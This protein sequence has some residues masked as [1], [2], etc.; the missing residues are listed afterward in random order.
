MSLEQIDRNLTTLRHIDGSWNMPQMPE[1]VML[2]LAI[3][4]GMKSENL[5]SL[6]YGA[7]NEI[8]APPTPSPIRL[9]PSLDAQ[10][11]D[12]PQIDPAQPGGGESSARFLTRW[13]SA[14]QGGDRPLEVS[15]TNNQAVFDWKRR[16]VQDGYIEMDDAELT[17]PR[18]RPEYNSINYD[19]TRDRM[20]RDFMG[21]EEGALSIRE[22]GN[23]FD[24]WLSPSG[25]ARA[26]IE[27]DL[28]WDYG[29]IKDEFMDWPSKARKWWSDVSSV[30]SP[31]GAGPIDVAKSTM[32]MVTGPLDEALVPALNWFLILSGVGNTFLSVKGLSLGAASVTGTKLATGMEATRRAKGIGP[33]A[34]ALTPA[35]RF[36]TGFAG[37]AGAAGTRLTNFGRPSGLSNYLVGGIGGQYTGNVVGRGAAAVGQ[38]MPG[39]AV[40][41][42][43]SLAE[44]AVWMG[45]KMQQWRNLRA[46]QAGKVGFQNVWKTGLGLRSIE[47]VRPGDREDRGDGG[48]ALEDVGI[49]SELRD[50]YLYPTSMTNIAGDLVFDLMFTPYTLF[51]PGTIKSVMRGAGMIKNRS[52]HATARVLPSVRKHLA[53][54]GHL[55]SRAI[56][57]FHDASLDFLRRTDPDLAAEYDKMAQAEG[58]GAALSKVFFNG[59][60]DDFGGAYVHALYSIGIEHAARQTAN[61]L[62]GVKENYSRNPIYNTVKAF[63]EGQTRYLDPHDMYGNLAEIASQVEIG[64]AVGQAAK[65]L[66]DDTIIQN[67]LAKLVDQFLE[68]S[69][70]A[71][72]RGGNVVD[73]HVRLIRQSDPN[74]LDYHHWRPLRHGEVPDVDARITDLDLEEYA[75]FHGRPLDEVKDFFNNPEPGIPGGLRVDLSPSFEGRHRVHSWGEVQA[76]TARR[77]DSAKSRWMWDTEIIAPGDELIP[78]DR[79]G[80]LKGVVHNHNAKRD[81]TIADLINNLESGNPN[82]A[83]GLHDMIPHTGN[84]PA[85]TGGAKG[86][87][88]TVPALHNALTDDFLERFSHWN[89]YVAA[90]DQLGEE[91]SRM[92]MDKAQYL[93][94]L[95]HGNR[96]LGLFPFAKDDP[97]RPRPYAGHLF[98]ESAGDYSYIEWINQGMYSPLVRALDQSKGRY[99]LARMGTVTKQ[100]AIEF[101]AQIKYRYDMLRTIRRFKT[102]GLIGAVD[103]AV[104]EVVQNAGGKLGQRA[105]ANFIKQ[106]MADEAAAGERVLSR[107]FGGKTQGKFSQLAEAVMSLGDDSPLNMQGL[108]DLLVEELTSFANSPEWVARFGLKELADAGHDAVE[109]ARKRSKQLTKES[110]WMAAE[111]DPRTLDAP[112]VQSMADK[113][114]KVVHGVSFTDPRK[115]GNLMPELGLHQSHLTS[116]L[117]LGLSRQNPYWLSN[118]RMRTTKSTLAGALASHASMV[119][120]PTLPVYKGQQRV[121]TAA[122]IRDEFASGDPNS[123]GVRQ[124]ID[125][126]QRMVDEINQQNQ[127]ALDAV[128]LGF[129]TGPSKIGTRLKASRTPYSVPDLGARR[130]SEM[131]KRIMALDYSEE[132]FHAIWEGLKKAR[133]LQDGL[134]VRGLA[135]LEDH[136]RSRPNLLDMTMTLGKHRAGDF[137]RN[138]GDGVKGL[139]TLFRTLPENMKRFA[140]ESG[141]RRGF[142]RTYGARA[143]TWMGTWLP[144]TG[145]TAMASEQHPDAAGFN[146]GPLRV[147]PRWGVLAGVPAAL[148]GNAASK[149]LARRLA[150]LTPEVSRWA[151]VGDTTSGVG[152]DIARLRD[153]PAMGLGGAGVGGGLGAGAGA[154]QEGVYEEGGVSGALKGAAAWGTAGAIG[155]GLVRGKA[156]EALPFRNPQALFS[157]TDWQKYAYM[158]DAYVNMRDYLR[159]SLSPIFDMSRY[160]E[161]L[162]LS[163]VVGSDVAKGMK[164][165]QSPTSFRRALAKGYRQ[166]GMDLDSASKAANDEW[167][168]VRNS[169]MKQAKGRGDFDW[170]NIDNM[171]RWFTSVGIMGFSP[172]S[173]MSSTYGQ[174]LQTGVN[175]DDAY[176]AARSIY[177][178]GL[179]G[180]SAAEQSVNMVFFPFSFMKKTVGHF[181][182]Y[183]T[184]DY[185]RAVILHDMMKTYEMMDEKYDLHE[186]YEAYL[187]ILGKMRRSNLF[188]YGLSLGEFGGPNA[189]FIRTL[190]HAPFIGQAAEAAVG[191]MAKQFGASDETAENLMVSPLVSALMP[192]A[193]SIKDAD[194]MNSIQYNVK[195]MF[196]LW[197]DFGHLVG[198]F[199]EQAEVIT[200][201]H[202]VTKREQNE[203]A[204]DEWNAARDG[205][206]AQLHGMGLPYSAVYRTSNPY[207]VDLKNWLDG[208]K[209]RLL[210]EYPSWGAEMVYSA[211]SANELKVREEFSVQDVDK[212]AVVPFIN[213]LAAERKALG[214][215]IPGSLT[216]IDFAPPEH[217]EKVREAA[218]YAVG[219]DPDFLAI[220]NRIWARDY[221]P[222]SAEVR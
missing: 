113:G 204:W 134:W 176:D 152:T 213:W 99:H 145:A 155:G 128:E 119:P 19:M 212:N 123:N 154:Y 30:P 45:S 166:R 93:K 65:A 200:S 102:W 24:D 130:Y 85:R 143:G 203:R 25:L 14:I 161:A 12:V 54:K 83:P 135:H 147:T 59:S 40:S 168:R 98:G 75:S 116:K 56:A 169:F 158:G 126:L 156:W 175:P 149:V 64:G 105:A 144:A 199:F 78:K 7:A 207:F 11:I 101:T 197:A 160:A 111:I 68:T 129:E 71:S 46:V 53:A 50:K 205:A 184:E 80:T 16:A 188:A 163:Q 138:E 185:S 142:G 52:L 26:A 108:E 131:K 91:I 23:I 189:P 180:R 8:A 13:M 165:N 51:E 107:A 15:E 84:I 90:S 214:D 103:E 221:G 150:G 22:T 194:D 79:V 82:L 219:V 96:R 55:G 114:Y 162:T 5:E 151:S 36:E 215:A 196:P 48:F 100:E 127:I 70:E 220:Y 120:A 60:D 208:E 112:F 49:V 38:A 95:S 186:K 18:W 125:N 132:E 118:L 34:R 164:L 1:Q 218:L 153:K 157:Q 9:P 74:S 178:Y 198:D 121:K 67:E 115:L 177:T 21:G 210:A 133:K 73:G 66:D 137:M 3:L 62:G 104:A 27:A 17:D 187:P 31:G 174:L 86:Y 88:P 63:L 117:T 201:P 124:I 192:N 167:T 94:A 4:P 10:Q 35:Q 110:N 109:T 58:P 81:G 202:H 139:F 195:R 191:G 72:A 106:A 172:Q 32:D 159:F 37:Q 146:A 222:I 87:S 190:H 179:T 122:G 41:G 217:H 20:E 44:Q 47:A 173:W 33:I 206:R 57:T 92:G 211:A 61:L 2:D 28:A 89:E 140:T 148:M 29:E 69:A 171:S 193:V 97:L 209:A 39:V 42:T 77:W 216:D 170:E 6:L 183:M 76:G 141:Y 182:D 181:A 43:S 136:L